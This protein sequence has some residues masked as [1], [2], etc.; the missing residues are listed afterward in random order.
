MPCL[1][2]PKKI[3]SLKFQI[4]FPL[5]IEIFRGAKAKCIAS[6]LNDVKVINV[7]PKRGNYV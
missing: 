7:F 1:K 4:A 6:T 5:F 2:K 3:N